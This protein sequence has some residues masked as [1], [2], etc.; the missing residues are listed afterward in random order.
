[1]KL[2]T[3]K[4]HQ[5]KWV[6]VCLG[7]ILAFVSMLLPLCWGNHQQVESET[8]TAGTAE[9]REPWKLVEDELGLHQ[10]MPPIEKDTPHERFKELA[11]AY[12]IDAS[13]IWTLEEYYW[14]TEWV[15]LCLIISETSW[16]HKGYGTSKC[17]NLGNVWN[18]DRGNRV[19]YAFMETWLE[20]V[21]MT[22]TNSNLWGIKT[23][24]CLSNAG[25]CQG[26]DDHWYRYATSDW[27]WERNMVACLS[28]IYWPIRASEFNIR[29]R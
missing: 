20:K 16:G 13:K 5:D 15:A 12:N 14:L 7:M 2:N 11:S 21:W 9:L 26:W 28:K 23:L 3:Y 4:T 1:M 6:L 22:L 27:N 10:E 29:Q 17:N 8:D 18:N 19:C 24:G 25:S